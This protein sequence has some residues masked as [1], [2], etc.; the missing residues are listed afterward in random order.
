MA[1]LKV[2]NADNYL[3]KIPMKDLVPVLTEFFDIN[4]KITPSIYLFVEEKM[5]LC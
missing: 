3:M 5:F 2:K 1:A 4:C